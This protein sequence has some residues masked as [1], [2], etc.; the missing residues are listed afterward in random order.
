MDR[1]GL[2]PGFSLVE[3]MVVVALVGFILGIG[4][5][6]LNSP[7]YQL[8]AA[9]FA[10]RSALQRTEFAAIKRNRNTYLDFDFNGDGTVDSNL[11]LW[12]NNNGTD[13]VLNSVARTPTVS[14]GCVPTAQGGPKSPPPS[15]YGRPLSDA[16]SFTGASNAMRAQFNPDGTSNTGTVY[17]DIGG[18]P[19]AGTY[20][21]V[22]NSI[23]HTD[24]WYFQTGGSSWQER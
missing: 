18:D 10:L 6:Y 11:T 16:V 3:L 7:Q 5:A 21:V 1:A 24:T 22:L 15:P 19:G 12:V 23:G 9:V 13:V 14:Y 4:A 8:K 2:K 17:L 20:A